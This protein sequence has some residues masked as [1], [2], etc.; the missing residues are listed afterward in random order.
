MGLKRQWGCG[1]SGQILLGKSCHVVAV[2]KRMF[3]LLAE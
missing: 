3:V 1:G 2:N